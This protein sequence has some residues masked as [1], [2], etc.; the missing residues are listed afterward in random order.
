MHASSSQHKTAPIAGEN[1]G[2]QPAGAPAGTRIDMT[3]QPVTSVP[4]PL[5]P[6]TRPAAWTI[7]DSPAITGR[8]AQITGRAAQI[9]GRA[10]QITG[11]C[12]PDVDRI[13][14]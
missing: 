4:R 6:G 5:L 9:T 14:R 10:A 11:P 12:A 7:G 2:E 13:C 3:W 8:A 1:D